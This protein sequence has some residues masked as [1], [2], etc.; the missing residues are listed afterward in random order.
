MLVAQADQTSFV[1][2]CL[3]LLR[4]EYHVGPN[5]RIIIM[6]HSMGGLVARAAV[7]KCIQQGVLGE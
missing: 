3:A 2:N 7:Q 6:G 4:D 5:R 1:V